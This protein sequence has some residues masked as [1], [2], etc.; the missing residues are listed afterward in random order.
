MKII[1]LS[2]SVAN[3]SKIAYLFCNGIR[4]VAI[5]E[6]DKENLYIENEFN[7][8]NVDDFQLILEEDL[9]H[10]IPFLKNQL[11]EQDE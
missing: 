3:G 9:Y 1:L 6:K 2:P 8:I 4:W 7:D 10:K 11:E 5:S